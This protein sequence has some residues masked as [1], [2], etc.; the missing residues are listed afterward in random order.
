LGEPF[1]AAGVAG[2]LDDFDFVRHG[3]WL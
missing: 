3:R 2:S 1:G